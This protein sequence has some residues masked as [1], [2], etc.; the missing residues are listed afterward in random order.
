MPYKYTPL[1]SP[2]EVRME[3]GDDAFYIHIRDYGPGIPEA[4]QERIFDK[5]TRLQRQDSQVA[6]TGLGLA[7]ARAAMRG[8][9]GDIRVR[10]H[11]EGG[12]IFTLTWPQWRVAA[13][14]TVSPRAGAQAQA[15]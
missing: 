9:G 7:L 11:A 12:A 6:G 4:D 2:I 3:T 10:N 14:S 15:V 1:G 13:A 8:Q 5:Y